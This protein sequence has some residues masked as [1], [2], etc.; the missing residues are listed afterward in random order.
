M[1]VSELRPSTTLV[2]AAV[3]ENCRGDLCRDTDLALIDAPPIRESEV[4]WK[5]ERVVLVSLVSV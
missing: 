5:I 2:N 3:L 1:K 4:G